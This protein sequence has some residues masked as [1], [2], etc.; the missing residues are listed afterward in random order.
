MV[1]KKLSKVV[2]SSD[3]TLHI[4]YIYICSKY[5]LFLQFFSTELRNSFR[6]ILSFKFPLAYTYVTYDFTKL[7]LSIQLLHQSSKMLKSVP[8][9]ALF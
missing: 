6:N 3:K 8:L 2:K 9:P 1:Y 5:V 7:N 4:Y